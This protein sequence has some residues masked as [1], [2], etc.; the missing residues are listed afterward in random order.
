MRVLMIAVA[1]AVLAAPLV[2]C[3]TETKTEKD[4]I[5]GSSTT[6]HELGGN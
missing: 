5:T 6:T 1:A 2:G 4:P 3:K